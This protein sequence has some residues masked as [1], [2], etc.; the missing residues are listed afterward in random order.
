MTDQWLPFD[1]F[2]S[3][4][5]P[6][7]D[8]IPSTDTD[9]DLP[10]DDEPTHYDEAP[11]IEES[12]PPPEKKKKS[13]ASA[14]AAKEKAEM[15]KTTQLQ[16]QD[17]ADKDMVLKYLD[18]EDY[19]RSKTSSRKPVSF[20]AARKG[21]KKPKAMSQEDIARH[22]VLLLKVDR[23]RTSKRYAESLARSRLPLQDAD[24][25]TIEQLENLLVR[26]GVVINNIDTGGGG[27]LSAG[28]LMSAGM[29]ENSPLVRRFANLEGY[30]SSLANNDQFQSLCEQISIEYSILD[31]VRPEIRLAMC[32]GQTAVVVNQINKMKA[33]AQ[34]RASQAPAAP[35]QPS[36]IVLSQTGAQTQVAPARSS[37][38]VADMVYDL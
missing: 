13:P 15:K 38:P 23:Y 32:M 12:P 21:G 3:D 16:K 4:L 5:P 26:I 10:S 29:A 25:M 28:L 17:D 36:H 27:M 33:A 24:D 20:P 34:G 14:V 9:T 19:G 6:S 2:P 37:L 31:N 11:Q 7:E 1:S 22:M 35:A 30:S 18:E 8:D